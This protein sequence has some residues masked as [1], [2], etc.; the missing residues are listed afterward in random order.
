MGI[1]VHK[2]LV[3][4][5]GD[6]KVEQHDIVDERFSERFRA[7]EQDWTWKS[8]EFNRFLSWLKENKEEAAE[9]CSSQLPLHKGK[10]RHILDFTLI[11]KER[12]EWTAKDFAYE[13]VSQ[14]EYGIPGV[15]G[16][17][18]GLEKSYQRCGDLLDS[19]V[20]EHYHTYEEPENWI[21]WLPCGI[22]PWLGMMHMPRGEV[23]AIVKNN[24]SRTNN[25]QYLPP[26]EYQMFVGNFSRHQRPIAGEEVAQYMREHYRPII[27]DAIMLWT[28]WLGDKLW[29]D[30]ESTIN[31]LRPALYCYWS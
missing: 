28:H 16:F 1:S 27:P 31:E 14:T 18:A 24:H 4:A 7:E 23:P 26:S 3:W 22:Y 6:L 17:V 5:L 19:Y 8:D 12:E 2:A 13:P 20:E 9:I 29:T 21:E 10:V 11:A 30:W 15:Y 25:W